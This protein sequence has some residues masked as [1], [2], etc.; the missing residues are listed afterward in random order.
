[1]YN[2]KINELTPGRKYYVKVRAKAPDLAVSEWSPVF[3]FTT[4][5]D[6]V[7]PHIVRNL[8]FKSEGDS[9]I[10]KWDKPEM[11]ADGTPCNDLTHYAIK[12]TD[13]ERMVTVHLQTAS[14]NF[15]LDINSNA[16][17]FGRLAGRVKIEVAGVD[18]VGNT[19]AFQEAIA[20][21]PAPNKVL[22]VVATAGVENIGLTWDL[23]TETDISHYEI[24][25]GSASNFT[26]GALSLR[27][28][29][30]SGTSAYS[31][32]TAS[33][34]PVFFK[35]IAV[36]KF[37]QKSVPSDPVSAQPK[38]GTDYDKT[39]PGV[40]SGFAVTQSLAPD[41]AS[42]IAKVTYTGLTDMDLDKYEIQYRKT[43]ETVA[44][45]SFAMIP[46]DQTS[47]E[48]RPLPLST[49]Y[50]FKIRAVDFNSNKGDWSAVVVAPGVKKTTLP[51]APTG[52]TVRGG[53]SNLMVTWTASTDPSM[54]NWA[55][56]YEV[57]VAKTLGFT[58]PIVVR[59]SS[60]L[61]SL[62]NL[63]KNSIYHVRVRSIDPYGNIGPWSVAASE[64]TGEVAESGNKSIFDDS[65]AT[66]VSQDGVP[67]KNGDIWYK[68]D[69]D[70]S[71]LAM[72]E[73]FDGNW[74]PKEVKNLAEDSVTSETISADAI[75]ARHIKAEEITGDKLAVNAAVVNNLKIQ[76]SIEI[77]DAHGHIKSSNYT[78]GGT[79]GFYMDQRQLIINQGKIKAAAIELQ[80]SSNIMPP[81]YA[82]FNANASAYA[83]AKLWSS[84]LS[85]TTKVANDGKFGGGSVQFVITAN[86]GF[87]GMGTSGTD[88]NIP[89]D[90]GNQYIISFYVSNRS[91]K[92]ITL[93]P[94]LY[95]SSDIT[96]KGAATS[97][98]NN[99]AWTRYSVVVPT[100]STMTRAILRFNLTAGAT[101]T[102]KLDGIQ[103]EQ[104]TGALNTPSNWSPPGYTSIDGESITTGSI[105]ST[106]PAASNPA[107]AAWSINTNGAARFADATIDGKL[108][109]GG[110]GTDE[111]K[112]ANV[113]IQSDQYVAGIEGWAI[114]GNGD[115]EFNNGT[116]R[117]I[118]NLGTVVGE[119]LRPS[120]QA[121]V[122]NIKL[123]TDRS[124]FR[125]IDVAG[126]RGVTFAYDRE[127]V[128]GQEDRYEPTTANVNKLGRYFIGP[129]TDR[130]VN[131]QSHDGPADTVYLDQP[132]AGV[133]LTSVNV[134]ELTTPSEEPSVRERQG[135]GFTTS[136]YELDPQSADRE[137][138]VVSKQSSSVR[139]SSPFYPEQNDEAQYPESNHD[140]VSR[141]AYKASKTKNI[142]HRNQA[143]PALAL[144]AQKYAHRPEDYL[145]AYKRESGASRATII[146]LD[147]IISDLVPGKTYILS[148]HIDAS[149]SS[150]DI[151]VFAFRG[152]SP[153]TP[154]GDSVL[155]ASYT[156]FGYVDPLT[157]IDPQYVYSM[158]NL[159]DSQYSI[160][161]NGSSSSISMV[162]ASGSYYSGY[163]YV[164]T[165]NARFSISTSD[166]LSQGLTV[167]MWIKT[168]TGTPSG[169]KVLF[170]RAS[171]DLKNEMWLSLDA[172]TGQLSGGFAGPLAA[173]TW[174]SSTGAIPQNE[175]M[176]VTLIVPAKTSG[177]SVAKVFVNGV[178][179][180]SHSLSNFNPAYST[181]PMYIA[182][183]YQNT[184]PFAGMIG[185]VVIKNAYL[186]GTDVAKIYSRGNPAE[187]AGA[188]TVTA[189]NGIRVSTTTA[190]RVSFSFVA[191]NSAR[192]P[193]AL[194]MV[195]DVGQPV[196]VY[197]LQLEQ[198]S[199]KDDTTLPLE[200][201][202]LTSPTPWSTNGIESQSS[203][204]L[205]IN[206]KPAIDYETW[207]ASSVA[208]QQIYTGADSVNRDS[209]AQM[210]LDLSTEIV[211]PDVG[212][213]EN[214]SSAK[215]K[216]S[217]TG[218]AYPGMQVDYM[219]AAAY[220]NWDYAPLTASARPQLT[221][222][223]KDL[224]INAANVST[225]DIN[226]G[227][228]R[229]I[230]DSFDR[231]DEN[232]LGY[233]WIVVGS[234]RGRI[235]NNRVVDMGS[236]ANV[237]V[238]H[239]NYHYHSEQ[240]T[241]FN[242]EV[243]ALLD[244]YSYNLIRYYSNST[245]MLSVDPSSK[246]YLAVRLF[247]DK[248]YV[249]SVVNG[250]IAYQGT[251]DVGMD[252]VNQG[253]ILKVRRDN[254]NVK[255]YVNGAIRV[256][257][258]V[259]SLPSGNRVGIAHYSGV[260]DD[261]KA[262]DILPGSSAYGRVEEGS[263]NVNTGRGLTIK[264]NGEV[265]VNNPGFYNI[266][267][268]VDANM[269]G[270]Y[271]RGYWMSILEMHGGYR[272]VYPLTGTYAYSNS[273][274][275]ITG[276]ATLYLKGRLEL[277]VHQDT[278]TT[279]TVTG[280]KW[281]I[282]RVI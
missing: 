116:F 216:W 65:D 236:S 98:A 114:K 257:I 47:A 138:A 107:I 188:R 262:V 179:I 255:V 182:N 219:P 252:V 161:N 265:W 263:I 189:A 197:K 94:E 144:G 89:I 105:S 54:A 174:T 225:G 211:D 75:L 278:T 218:V 2:L 177:A 25:V 67:F 8:T 18:N 76:S 82:S 170:H 150:S 95:Q 154:L 281:V 66:G 48:I 256:N 258:T 205:S 145:F 101:A 103:V 120:M 88:L 96:I 22:N 230:T 92:V 49:S 223:N 20:Q 237:G 190:N 206:A 104:K 246:G 62:T 113:A 122:S 37:N 109:V 233:P 97:I 172:S 148:A 123:Y 224:T 78:S 214:A 146:E 119:S 282:V 217:S 7:P 158:A 195:G 141:V 135:F 27:G 32:Q 45:W 178:E 173:S 274:G 137:N 59:T 151:G 79:A 74:I 201:R 12:L 261:F 28:Q 235:R 193:L 111:A 167:S 99:S 108:I 17:L 273:M 272:T 136:R 46:S 4:S 241:G 194:Q 127:P 110:Y 185:E 77:N 118:L 142:L 29:A 199:Y 238:M 70:N 13:I 264:G 208:T 166:N 112:N 152:T 175:W 260:I 275:Q 207:A 19:G 35:I 183:N 192:T 26:P 249:V 102:F 245:L 15:V 64:N 212:S 44:P 187:F 57:Q 83:V 202:N 55:G 50:D 139:L 209:F 87:V 71:I 222:S 267:A 176:H 229:N 3:E 61:A 1:M 5:Q 115:V 100:P 248:L 43:D 39:P 51:A 168:L 140:F 259:P 156:E 134:G 276:S 81:L 24:H 198:L 34:S 11:N 124:T 181:Q 203:A 133:A 162:L 52:V 200:I 9:F 58:D 126:I 86:T 253:V 38:L 10:A 68:T 31:H 128:A 160:P 268:T 266:Y 6:T 14:T 242:Q 251:F 90:G 132:P 73:F 213:Q 147:N 210:E 204:R 220:I 247:R 129:T 221:S 250:A 21:N 279:S 121:S 85:S 143:L 196:Y 30:A 277:R 155:A 117:G 280:V 69:A 23:G 171:T 165:S 164:Q 234:P 40:V 125:N 186:S 184:Q 60:T 240:L 254:S 269:G 41:N 56:V 72:W 106:A 180:K 153:L 131:I 226:P 157:S 163:K 16:Q 227:N 84:S 215:Y 80:D 33:L 36:D 228:G 270:S 231:A 159:R 243:S 53:M 130:S 149:Y 271:Q 191:P 91:G 93:Q 42:A 244:S 239:D 169:A 232:P 63:E